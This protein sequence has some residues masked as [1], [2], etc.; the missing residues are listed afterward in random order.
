MD[1]VNDRKAAKKKLKLLTYNGKVD[2]EVFRKKIDE[3][4]KVTFLPNK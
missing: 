4:Y 2:A 1:I 3:A